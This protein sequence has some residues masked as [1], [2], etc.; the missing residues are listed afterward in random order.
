VGLKSI[1]VK[2]MGDR[3]VLRSKQEDTQVLV[4]N[5]C[6]AQSPTKVYEP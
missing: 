4:A 6:I 1:T 5:N 3:K 2:E